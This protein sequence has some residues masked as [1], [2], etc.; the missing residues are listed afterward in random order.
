MLQMDADL[1]LRK[2]SFYR[3]KPCENRLS[4]CTQQTIIVRSGTTDHRGIGILKTIIHLEMAET[5][6]VQ[7]SHNCTR[8]RQ[9]KHNPGDGCPAK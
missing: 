9:T 8:C 4:Y 3:K 5:F 6:R 1:T 2:A 7:S